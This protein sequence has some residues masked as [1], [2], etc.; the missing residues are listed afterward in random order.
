M[1][2]HPSKETLPKRE[3]DEEIFYGLTPELTQHIVHALDKEDAETVREATSHLHAAD[4]ADIFNIIS[5]EERESLVDILRESFDP[6]ILVELE[7][8]VKEEVIRL[9]GTKGSAEAIATLDTDDAMEVIEDLSSKNQKEILGAISQA[10]RVN[11]EEGLA[12][13]EN[14]A[15]RLIEKNA[16]TIPPYWTVGQL[17]AYLRCAENIP[18]HFSQVF[19][20]DPAFRP[21]GVV[22]LSHIACAQETAVLRD[23]MD[24]D[25]YM[26]YPEMDQEEVALMF[27]KYALTSAPVINKEGRMLGVINID[28]VI[29]V[30][31]EEAQ[32]DL[33][34]LG[35]IFEADLH[36][37]FF[38]T[39]K[40]RFPWLFINLLTAVLASIVIWLFEGTIEKLAAIAALMPIVASMG[41]NSGTQTL[42]VTVRAIATKDITSMNVIR[43]VMKE[44]S[45]G[46]MNGLLFAM[47]TAIGVYIWLGNMVVSLTFGAAIILTLLFA[48]LAG[49]LL[50]LGLVRLGVDPAIA[51][52]VFLTTVT[53]VVAF[54]TFLGITSLLLI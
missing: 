9:L 14:S 25:M 31:Q 1:A 11:L 23:I 49:T 27:R 26:V 5:R 2:K 16:V 7:P 41:G 6:D 39:L 32:E 40:R 34:H 29:N 19:L 47:V 51:A 37:N 43:V 17:I 44:L 45:V 33:M 21:M 4:I 54:A 10:Q 3:K 12:Y 30:V 42:T 8:D 24:T 50:P 18:Q 13:P 38:T 36:S 48:G 52:G 28:D 15:G 35:G 20:V 53:D 22:K 46:A